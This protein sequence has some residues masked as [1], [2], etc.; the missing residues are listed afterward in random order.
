MEMFHFSSCFGREMFFWFLEN[1][2]ISS[3]L[4]QNLFKPFPF[5]RYYYTEALNPLIESLASFFYVTYLAQYC[6]VLRVWNNWRAWEHLGSLCCELRAWLGCKIKVKD[7]TNRHIKN[8]LTPSYLCRWTRM[9]ILS[10]FRQFAAENRFFS[11]FAD[12]FGLIAP[13]RAVR[14]RNVKFS[15]RETFKTLVVCL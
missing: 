10:Q 12:K 1:R 6:I 3:R 14:L 5:E 7:V 11:I 8:H 15:P 9:T 4:F 2:C 13:K